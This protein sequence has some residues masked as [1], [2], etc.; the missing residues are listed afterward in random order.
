[1]TFAELLT[2]MTELRDQ[3]ASGTN[4]TTDQAEIDR[5]SEQF[6]AGNDALIA[7]AGGHPKPPPPRIKP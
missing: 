1:M 7:A 2:R 4:G 3:W 6:I 5:Y